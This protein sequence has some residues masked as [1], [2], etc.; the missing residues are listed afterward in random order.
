MAY[1]SPVVLATGGYD[2]KIRFWEATTGACTKTLSFGDSQVNCLSISPDKALLAAGGNSQLQLFDIKGSSSD[3]KPLI[4]YEG[5]SGNVMSVGFQKDLKWLYTGSED[6]TVR[7]W[8]PRSNLSTRTY[9]CGSSVNTVALSPNQAELLTGDQNGNVKIWD[10]NA[11][12]CREELTPVQDI[13]VRSISIGFDASLVAVGSHKGKVFLYQPTSEKKLEL[14]GDFQAH[15]DYLLKCVVSPD[16][17]MVATTSADKTIKL[18]SAAGKLEATLAQ[19]QR[20]VW[21]AV[22]SADSLY[23]V[24]CSSDYSARL[25]DLRTGEVIRLYSAGN[26]L[27]VTCVA[28]ND[29]EN[30]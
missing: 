7:V 16:V 12:R 2:H 20:W 23:L 11:D 15:N 14:V 8:D 17:N 10:L 22:F 25:W 6:G 19:H 30:N 27:A 4:S 18:W 24:S 3:S 28:L 29:S 5:H 21:D 13:P 1:A 26:N 9:D